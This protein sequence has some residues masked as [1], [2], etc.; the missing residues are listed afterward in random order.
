MTGIRLPGQDGDKNSR[1]L[2]THELTLEFCCLIV[3]SEQVSFSL[4]VQRRYS[5]RY[6]SYVP[7]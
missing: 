6:G 2:S 4:L 7:P 1:L 5:K 3:C